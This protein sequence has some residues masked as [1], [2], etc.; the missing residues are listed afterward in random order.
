MAYRL[1]VNRVKKYRKKY[2]IE[3]RD[4]ELECHKKYRSDNKDEF[5]EYFKIEKNRIQTIN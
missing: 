5:I 1:I 3:H 2:Y 4:L